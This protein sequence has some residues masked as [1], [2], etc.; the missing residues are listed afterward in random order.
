MRLLAVARILVTARD[1]R[2]RRPAGA[3]RAARGVEAA[4][5]GFVTACMIGAA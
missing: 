5:R 3:S 1:A 4:A 2:T